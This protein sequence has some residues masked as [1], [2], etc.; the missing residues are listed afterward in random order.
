[1]PNVH[2]ADKIVHPNPKSETQFKREEIP[3]PIPV[4]PTSVPHPPCTV[5]QFIGRKLSP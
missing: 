5:P 1:M 3:K 2:G 4:V